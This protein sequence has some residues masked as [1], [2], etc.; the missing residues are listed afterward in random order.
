MSADDAIGG[1]AGASAVDTSVTGIRDA[2]RRQWESLLPGRSALRDELWARW[3]E[4]HRRYHDPRHLAEAL[5]ALPALAPGVDLRLPRLALWFHDAVLTGGPTDEERSAELAADRLSAAG[6][7]ASDIADVRRLVLVTRDH[8]PHAGDTAEE[9]VSDADLAVLAAPP[10]RYD[11]SV[12]DL[13]RERTALG[14][15]WTAWRQALLVSRLTGPIFFSAVG[16]H[17]LLPAAHANMRRELAALTR[18]VPRSGPLFDG[19]LGPKPQV[20]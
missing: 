17:S 3:T 9:V 14:L 1:G 10:P 15:E 11:E 8:R 4:P 13:R 20:G 2:L 18:G 12:A 6:L 5:D 16:A 19:D 7:P